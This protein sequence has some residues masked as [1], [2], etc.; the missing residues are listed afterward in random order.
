[1]RGGSVTRGSEVVLLPGAGR[2]P[3]EW[4]GWDTPTLQG[5]CEIPLGWEGGDW[6]DRMPASSGVGAA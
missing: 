1:M 5:N 3:Q 2:V 4:G 6:W